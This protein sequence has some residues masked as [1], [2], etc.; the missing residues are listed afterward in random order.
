MLTCTSNTIL[1]LRNCKV[2]VKVTTDKSAM[3]KYIYLSCIVEKSVQRYRMFKYL[4]TN[5]TNLLKFL[6]ATV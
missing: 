2:N 4:F 1:T 3:M 6:K 5:Q